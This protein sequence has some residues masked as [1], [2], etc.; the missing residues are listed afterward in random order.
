M[1]EIF[2]RIN[3]SKIWVDEKYAGGPGPNIRS[4][5][6]LIVD[7]KSIIFYKINKESTNQQT[8]LAFLKDFLK[9]IKTKEQKPFILVMDN[10]AVHKT[11]VIRYFLI[12]NKINVLFIMNIL[13]FSFKSLLSLNLLNISE[14]HLSVVSKHFC[15]L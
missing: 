7:N 3:I 15:L 9:I 6:S 1:L 12:E 13:S 10:L 11:S 8:F 4:N 5:L 2:Q 14:I